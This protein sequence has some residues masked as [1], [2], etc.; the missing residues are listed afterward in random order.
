MFAIRIG[1]ICLLFFFTYLLNGQVPEPAA[2][3]SKPPSSSSASTR[4]SEFRSK[5]EK[6]GGKSRRSESV[7]EQQQHRH[8]AELE[9]HEVSRQ[10]Q[11]QMEEVQRTRDEERKQLLQ[12]LEYQRTSLG[13][14][15][16]ELRDRNAAV[17]RSKVGDNPQEINPLL[18]R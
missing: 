16:K 6:F 17:S 14:E 1:H 4:V 13:D 8:R 5:F 12:R 10:L 18:R 11:K 9:A 3:S 7:D 15:I 2:E